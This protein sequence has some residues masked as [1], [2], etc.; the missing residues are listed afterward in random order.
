M[1]GMR[2]LG[3]VPARG[4]SKGVPGKNIRLLAGK[5]LLQYTAEAALA[6]SRLSRVILSTENEEIAEVGRRC[7]LEVPFMRPT[8][9]AADDTPTL[10]VVQ[11]ALRKLEAEGDAFDAVLI[12]QPTTPLRRPEDIDG[13]IELLERTGADSVISFVDVG[14]KHPAR[15]KFIDEEGRVTDPPFSERFEGQRRQ[16]LPT[17][18]LR[19]GSIYLTR[20]RVI[21]EQNSVKGSDCRAW[22]VPSERTC[23]IDTEFDFFIAEQLLKLKN[24]T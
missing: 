10:P 13:A 6:A 23:N 21:M 20:T 4:G 22:I 18:Y 19:E 14:E 5:P 3:L 24:E 17:L 2:V 8:A 16:D 9:L 7:G 15:M 12:L 11:D 1:S